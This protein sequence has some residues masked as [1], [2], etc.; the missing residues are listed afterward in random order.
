MIGS[1]KGIVSEVFPGFLLLDVNGVGY[2]VN[3]SVPTLAECVQ[4]EERRFYVH[5]HVRE[6]SRDLYGFPSHGDLAMFERLISISGIGPK[7]G[8]TIMSVGSLETIR[9][10]IMAGD[11]ALLTS[12]PGVGTKTAQKIVLELKGQLVDAAEGPAEDRD[13]IEALMS[14]GYSSSQAREAL[15]NVDAS[16]TDTSERIRKALKSLSKK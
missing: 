9:R 16:V 6:D 1:L 7:V 8:L 3:A 10:G 4:G 12:V 2:R 15:K 5:D 14:L 11:L 13:V